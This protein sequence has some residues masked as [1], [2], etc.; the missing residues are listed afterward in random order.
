MAVKK[1]KEKSVLEQKLE[2]RLSGGKFRIMNEKMY[3]GEKMSENQMKNYHYLYGK[4]IEKWPV[5]PAV[6]VKKEIQELV[7]AKEGSKIA[8]LGCGDSNKFNG[9]KNAELNFYDK[10]P[11]NK[12]VVQADLCKIPVEKDCFDITV[13]CL[14]LMVSDISKS[15][16]EINRI[17]KKDGFFIMAEVRSRIKSIRLF[18]SKI[19]KYG[20]KVDNINSSNKYFTILRFIKERS[21]KNDEKLPNLKLEACKYKKQ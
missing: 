9:I 17:T 3:K 2:S 6:M 14:S 10:Y 15:V 21:I 12:K 7:N 8:D 11:A 18:A 1:L 5:D 16:R 13:C 20:F 4:Q 19:E